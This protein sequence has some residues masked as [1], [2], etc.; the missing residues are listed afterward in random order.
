ML[1]ISHFL[2]WFC[3]INCCF[4]W[5]FALVDHDGVSPEDGFLRESANEISLLSQ[6]YF[7][8]FM[9]KKRDLSNISR[10]RCE[11]KLVADYDFFRVIGNNNY[12]SA[13]RYIVGF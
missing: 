7:G 12:A 9:R 5:I 13:A 3:C 2:I 6:S 4:E 1:F 10:N 11:L 8:S